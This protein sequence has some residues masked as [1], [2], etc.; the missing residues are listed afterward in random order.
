[1]TRLQLRHLA[2]QSTREPELLPVLQ[3]ALLESAAYGAEFE[4][5][6]DVA[7]DH[8]RR[9]GYGVYVV[10]FNPTGGTFMIVA[11]PDGDLALALRHQGWV[12][13]FI[14]PRGR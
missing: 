9:A 7:R 1:M 10:A 3:D 12:P 6:M 5:M 8:A 13:V 14:A 11:T 2:L 4:L